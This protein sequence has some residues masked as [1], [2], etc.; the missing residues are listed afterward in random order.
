MAR[1][2]SISELENFPSLDW[3]DVAPGLTPEVRSSLE[4]IL[5]TQDGTAIP[6]E[7]AYALAHA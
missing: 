3:F 2:L 5:E 1:H 4:R 7:E 6:L